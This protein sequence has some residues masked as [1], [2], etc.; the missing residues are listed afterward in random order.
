M[1]K[2]K[3]RVVLEGIAVPVQSRVETRVL[4][5]EEI[6]ALLEEGRKCR[7]EFEKR[8]KEMH[9]FRCGCHTG[10]CV[11]HDKAR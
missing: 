6:K 8:S 1:T 2:I 5:E 10:Q 9:T 11:I 4:T 7:I 3:N